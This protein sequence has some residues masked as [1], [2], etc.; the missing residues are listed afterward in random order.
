MTCKFCGHQRR[1][2]KAH[3][4]PEAFF[5]D[6]R[7]AQGALKIRSDV[8]GE[9][10][11]KAPIGIYDKTILC[12]ECENIFQRWDDYGQDLLIKQR[13]SHRP[14]HHEGRILYYQIED[15]DYANLMLFFVSTIWRAA[16]STQLFYSKVMLGPYE[17]VAKDILKSNGDK[18]FK[19]FSVV[20]CLFEGKLGKTIFEPFRD[21]FDGFNFLRL[22]LSGFMALI[23]TDKRLGPDSFRDFFIRPS[24]PIQVLVCNLRNGKEL[25]TLS[26]IKR[27][28]IQTQVRSKAK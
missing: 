16:V 15:F 21:K 5:R 13:N 19:D 25:K 23:K 1:L 8:K 6:L 10:S 27:A 22:Y 17:S 20:L 3:I 18:G 14:F 9:F 2:I 28:A 12:E 26:S 11:K 24:T 7:Q 4:I